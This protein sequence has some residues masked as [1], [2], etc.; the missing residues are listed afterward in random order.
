MQHNLE[1]EI[2]KRISLMEWS[3]VVEAARRQLDPETITAAHAVIEREDAAD[4]RRG[5]DEI[6]ATHFVGLATDRA[7]LLDDLCRVDLEE[8]ITDGDDA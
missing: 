4:S 7:R 1:A 5:F 6:A 8:W 2:Q 3:D